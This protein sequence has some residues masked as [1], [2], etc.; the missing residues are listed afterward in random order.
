MAR[1]LHCSYTYSFLYI[2]TLFFKV[3]DPSL[4][5]RYFIFDW[6]I[7][8]SYIA[9][10][11]NSYDAPL[12]IRTS[13]LT[14]DFRTL[15]F[16]NNLW[17]YY[18]ATIRKIAGSSPDEVDFFS[19]YVILPAALWPWGRLSLWQKCVPGIFLGVKAGRPV[20][21]ADKLTA[22]C[23]PIFYKMWEHRRLTALWE[24]TACYRDTFGFTLWSFKTTIFL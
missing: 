24:F 21:K 17:P 14:T 16:L 9:H 6:V 5:K 2:V 18:Y 10:F 1:P 19:M 23:E 13:N 4:P 15:I 12:N 7:N 8:Y 3:F 20:C 11:Q 22:I